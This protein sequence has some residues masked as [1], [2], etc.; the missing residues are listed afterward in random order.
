[1]RRGLRQLAHQSDGEDFGVGKSRRAIIAAAKIL[2]AAKEL[3]VGV[4]HED[5]DEDNNIFP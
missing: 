4:G 2:G 1:M 5:I 3:V